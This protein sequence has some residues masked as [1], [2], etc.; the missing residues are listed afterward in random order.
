[1]KTFRETEARHVHVDS[2]LL[3]GHTLVCLRVDQESGPFDISGHYPIL[4]GYDRTGNP[5]YVAAVRIDLS[6]Y[7]DCVSNNANAMVYMDK[8]GERHIAKEFFVLA[9][10]HDPIDYFP[11]DFQREQSRSK[12]KDPTGPVC[13]RSFWPFTDVAYDGKQYISDDRHLEAFLDETYFD[14]I[15]GF[16]DVLVDIREYFSQS[17]Y[18]GIQH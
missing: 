5:L 4:A 1:M 2:M 9:L 11:P 15:G 12:G 16:G 3:D 10:R 8:V 14:I 7:F 18:E 17:R 6:W 13:W